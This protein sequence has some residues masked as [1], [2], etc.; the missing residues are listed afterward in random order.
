MD[1]RLLIFDCDGVLIDSEMLACRVVAEELAEHGILLAGDEI[2]ERFAGVTDQEM[3][4]ILAAETGRHLPDNFPLRVAD[5]AMTLFEQEL[6]AM[7]GVSALLSKLPGPR[8]VASNSMEHRLRQSLHCTGL[9]PFFAG[10][11]VFSSEAVARG[12]PAPDLHLHAAETMGFIPADCLVIEDSVTGVTAARTA[13][14]AVIGFTGASHAGPGHG[15][16]LREAGAD[17]IVGTMGELAE[18]LLT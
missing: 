10:N 7:P 6:E 18:L 12:K 15:D 11:A 13:G 14:M 2:A 4:A 8:C 3:A 5:R 1:G 16:A 9:M 17:R